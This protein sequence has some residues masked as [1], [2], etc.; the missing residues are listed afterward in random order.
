MIPIPVSGIRISFICW[1]TSAHSSI[2]TPYYFSTTWQ[3]RT[4]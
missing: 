2:L 3:K 1:R 4:T